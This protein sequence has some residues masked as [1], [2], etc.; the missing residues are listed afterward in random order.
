VLTN[1]T[2]KFIDKKFVVGKLHI[3]GH[4]DH[5]C[6]FICHPDLYPDLNEINTVVVEQINFWVGQFK[7]ITK[8]M[9]YF[10]YLFFL[11]ILFDEYNEL[12]TVLYL[13]LLIAISITSP[14]STVFNVINSI[15]VLQVLKVLYLT[16]IKILILS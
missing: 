7:Y 3:Q 10:R 11:F 13:M 16:Q 9:N 1:R 4:T 8:H 12:I 6:R 14:K 2:K 15:Q 5:D